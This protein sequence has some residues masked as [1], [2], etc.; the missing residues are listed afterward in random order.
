MTPQQPTPN[1][2][3]LSHED[4]LLQ[5]EAVQFT[6]RKH[7]I[8]IILIYLAV[9]GAAAVIFAF[10]VIVAPDIF[11]KSTNLT[12]FAALSVF[13]VALL[14]FVLFIATY[15]YRES[16]II[17]TNR[18][19][20]QVLQKGLFVRKVSRLSF[21]DVEDVNAEQRGILQSLFNYGTLN[22]QTAG[23]IEN[24]TF[25]YC[26]KPNFDAEQILEARQGFIEGESE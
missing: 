13:A 2:R 4:M 3:P 17:V 26:P 7:I 10:I 9:L 25:T 19:L 8:G 24:F 16:H 5:N 1:R 21:A 23:E 20:I 12:S 14:A 6:I 15:I 18:S 11:T 22:I